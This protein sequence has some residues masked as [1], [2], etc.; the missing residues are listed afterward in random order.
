[1]PKPELEKEFMVVYEAHMDAVFR[2]CYFRVFHRERAKEI[3]HEA[4][5]RTWEAIAGGQDI[6]NIRAFVYRV[7]GHLIIDESRKKKSASLEAL[8][9]DG[10]DPSAEDPEM[11]KDVVDI[12]RLRSA[13]ERLDPAYRDAVRMRYME[14]LSPKEIAEMTGESQ[15][16]ISVR[17]YRGLKQLRGVLLS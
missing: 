12:A 8:A 9:E 17:I 15:N 10:F 4:F 1:M 5:T 3:M 7:A 2:H 14:A 16:V 13:L 6:Q 11:G